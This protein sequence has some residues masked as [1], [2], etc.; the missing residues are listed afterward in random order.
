MKPRKRIKLL[1]ADD[2]RIVRQGVRSALTDYKHI[3]IVGEAANGKDAVEQAMKA[4]P[5]IVMMDLSMPL[6]G[7]L[8][9]T[10]ILRDR[11][12]DIKVLALTM[13]DSRQYVLQILRSGGR[14]YV[15]KD[16]SPEELVR[17]IEAVDRGD[18]FFSPG[19]SR[20][21]L[22]HVA[23]GEQVE[24]ATQKLTPRETSVLRL[25]AEGFSNKE[26][27]A[28]LALSVRT[29]ET[30]RERIMRKLQIRTVA[31]LTR[32]AVSEGLVH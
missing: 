20:L 30:H 16:T 3:E 12:P 11:A 17:A 31:G 8:E 21:L 14:G 9:A 22:D 32:F 6:M 10:R 1:L 15:L 28:Q 2:H 24:T 27:A 26:I 18:A 7:G 29:I 4:R 19:V 23:V 25:I 5:D 13:H